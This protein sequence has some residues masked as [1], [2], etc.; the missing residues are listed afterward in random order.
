MTNT[1]TLDRPPSIRRINIR[2]Q[3]LSTTSTAPP[4]NQGPHTIATRVKRTITRRGDHMERS[5]VSTWREVITE[6]TE[7]NLIRMET[8]TGAATMLNSNQLRIITWL[9]TITETSIIAPS[10]YMWTDLIAIKHCQQVNP[11]LVRCPII[12]IT[13][14][15]I[16]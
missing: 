2:E 12:T 3:T 1:T 7:D 15:T 8:L 11:P 13:T 10:S 9:G 6:R 16:T 5:T 4:L 14:T